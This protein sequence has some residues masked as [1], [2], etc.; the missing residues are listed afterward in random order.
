MKTKQFFALL[1][2]IVLT[3]ACGNVKEAH[4]PP[5]LTSAVTAVSASLDSLSNSLNAAATG[6]AQVGADTAMVRSELQRLYN[7][8]SFG[9]E[10]VFTTPEGILQLIEPA[11]YYPSQGS[12]ISQQAHIIKAFE[13]KLPALSDVF[14]VVEGFQAVVQIHPI[15]A[16]DRL[17]GGVSG[18]F[19][20]AYLIARNVVPIIGDEP[21]EI[22]VMEKTGVVLYNADASEIGLNV[23]TDP[24]YD[25][26][27]KM[28]LACE[29][30]AGEPSGMTSFPYYETGSDKIINR[31]VFWE[32]LTQEGNEWKFIWS[33]ASE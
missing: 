7:E 1:A 3:N 13:T 17:L 31:K 16:E 15:M 18:L 21:F 11:A 2:L 12:D 27:P 20:P 22:W 28:K 23:F 29:K 6:L 4:I 19:S 30:I 14:S 24:R 25:Q 8:C 33:G 10:F 5:A 26:F 32:T 9:S